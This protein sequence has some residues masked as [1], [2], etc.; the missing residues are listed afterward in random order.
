MAKPFAELGARCDLFHPRGQAI[1]YKDK[2]MTGLKGMPDSQA[3]QALNALASTAVMGHYVSALKNLSL[4]GPTLYLVFAGA[5][6][7]MLLGFGPD[8]RLQGL[9]SQF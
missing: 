6:E 8:L 3:S 4:L 7:P 1:G 9:L 2:V 5:R